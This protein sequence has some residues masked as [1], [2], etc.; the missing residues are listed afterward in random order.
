MKKLFITVFALMFVLC[1]CGNK[2]EEKPALT[3]EQENAVI[4]DTVNDT[5]FAGKVTE[6]TDKEITILMG[7]SVSETF[8]LN[9]K[10]K[11]DIEVLEIKAGQRVV[12]NFD[13]VENREITSVEVEL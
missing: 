13:T 1:G 4:K 12:I 6:I 10:A 8:K 7:D 5:A 11:K 9:E 3:P 2:T